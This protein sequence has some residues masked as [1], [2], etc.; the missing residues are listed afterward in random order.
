MALKHR[1]IFPGG[2]SIVLIGPHG[3]GKSGLATIASG[4]MGVKPVDIEE[5]FRR[6][7]GVSLAVYVRQNENAECS[8]TDLGIIRR[9]FE[10]NTENA[11]IVW[12]SGCVGKFAYAVLEEY[13]QKYSII[14]VARS[15]KGIQQYLKVP[16]LSRVRQV[17]ELENRVYRAS[18]HYEFFNLDEQE[19]LS[20]SAI[21]YDSSMARSPRPLRLKRMEESFVRFLKN[22][23]Q[24]S[25][26]HTR[27]GS[28]LIIPLSRSPR[29]Y[30]LNLPLSQVSSPD[31]DIQS[32]DCGADACQLEVDLAEVHGLPV[33]EITNKIS[34]AYAILT[35]FFDG[36]V[37]YHL[38]CPS[39][40]SRYEHLY[41]DLLRH[42]PR[43]G[44]DY[45]TLDL[46][47]GSSKI[48]SLLPFR[49]SPKILGIYH[50]FEPGSDGWSTK[51]RWEILEHASTI[52][53]LDGIRLT[54]VANSIED[55][56]A[57]IAFRVA[58]IRS[59]LQHPF[60]VAYNT[61][62]LGRW[63]RCENEILTPVATPD[64]KYSDSELSVQSI[65][66]AL[67]SSFIYERRNFY[68]LGRDLSTCRVP[69]VLRAAY[70]FFGLPHSTHTGSI[71]D[72]RDLLNDE[73]LG[74]VSML[75][76]GYKIS[77][78]PFV[79]SYSEHAKNIGAINT[80]IPI[81][82]QSFEGVTTP[83]PDFWKQRN[84][85]NRVV[86]LYGENT[87]WLS[88][89][90]CIKRNLSPA[91]AITKNTAALVIGA[92]GMA[93]AALYALL[94]MGI[95]NVVIY[96]RTLS[97]ALA[98]ASRFRGLEMPEYTRGNDF[99]PNIRIIDSLQSDWDND[100]AQPTVIVSCVPT[101]GTE[102]MNTNFIL[103]L[104]WMRSSTGGVVL[105]LRYRPVITPLLQQI[106][107]HAM[108]GWVG[109]DGLENLAAR[110]AI[111]FE[112]FTGRRAPRNLARAEA[113]RVY[114]DRNMQPPDAMRDTGM[115]ETIL[116]KG[117]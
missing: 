12:P 62:S 45:M 33:L 65:Q 10:Q 38:H 42:G 30:L 113:L 46:K 11:V 27:K 82:G 97:N 76:P 87:D 18:S 63:S 61:G 115:D 88:I 77:I 23:M 19:L 15:A 36:P 47:L 28:G 29:T 50:D 7:Y 32:L 79:S 22:I 114:P 52:P 69:H 72:L 43:I 57:V 80:I 102:C 98:L 91:N 26:H 107:E 59:G 21:N 105:E 106:R 70:T 44:V 111:D 103:P 48:S 64:S 83:P 5:I 73:F 92:G 104:Q 108:R 110:T 20:S 8:P 6:R 94:Q 39:P 54:Q 75:N 86:G 31:F 35:R 101:A 51:K 55:N 37:V 9:V 40:F 67:Y 112:L 66:N 95:R 100:L 93:H 49:G 71:D 90:E 53:G 14:F 96:N 117:K 60:L 25:P 89:S 3:A 13:A 17:V 4:S 74:G 81:R 109:I 85:A 41:V 99:H 84:T 68:L 58:A 34:V 2:S 116:I 1:D 78:A 24:T 16:D 56:S